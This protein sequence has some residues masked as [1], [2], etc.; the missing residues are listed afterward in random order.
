[1]QKQTVVSPGLFREYVPCHGL[2]LAFN[3][4]MSKVRLLI[5]QQ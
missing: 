4:S 5:L 2:F 1:M 3:P